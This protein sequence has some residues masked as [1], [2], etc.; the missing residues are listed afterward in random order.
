MAVNLRRSSPLPRPETYTARAGIA[1]ELHL[2]VDSILKALK[3]HS[4]RINTGITLHNDELSVLERLYYK[5]KNQ[6]R[7]SLFWRTIIETR[8]HCY[9]LRELSLTEL[10]DTL[11]GAFYGLGHEQQSSQKML[12]AAWTHI[13]DRMYFMSL[14][15]R[16]TA[17]TALLQKA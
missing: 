2:R 17:A 5:G 14:Q 3:I 6:H 9:R 16:L 13:P 8:R 12:K 15:D 7:A 4:R 10:V 1:L 11:R